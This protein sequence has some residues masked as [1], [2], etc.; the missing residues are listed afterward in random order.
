MGQE[1][2]AITGKKTQSDN[3]LTVAGKLNDDKFQ[4]VATACRWL[5]QAGVKCTVL[6]L[7]PTDYD[8]WLAKALDKTG[9]SHK[10]NLVALVGQPLQYLGGEEEFMQWA[11]TKHGYSDSKTNAILYK[12]MAKQAWEKH[13]LDSGRQYAKM[14][15]TQDDADI[16][17]ILIEIF[18]DHCPRT[19]AQF[20]GLLKAKREN[21]EMAYEGCP[22]HRVVSG[23][24][25]QSGD[26]VEGAGN[27]DPGYSFP[28]ETFKVR[29]DIPGIIGCAN[30]LATPHTNNSHFYITFKALPFLDGK[31]V[32]F[33]RVVDGLR[34]LRVIEKTKLSFERP[35]KTVRI[36]KCEVLDTP[37]IS[38][39][40]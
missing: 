6:S 27:G 35:T 2:G 26:V 16:G 8:Q 21:G 36:S 40:S 37:A 38:A 3:F 17:T 9:I 10:S 11:E 1:G 19:A 25:M 20:I 34:V 29:H 31:K 13:M 4:R 14:T 32:A 39:E 30:K 12:R 33:A 28:D 23:G 15:F 5:Q 24:W 18:T 22:V 7:L